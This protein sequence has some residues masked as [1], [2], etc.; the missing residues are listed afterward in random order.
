MGIR[1]NEITTKW[2]F[3]TDNKV[4]MSWINQQKENLELGLGS[5]KVQNI[6]YP[7]EYQEQL[8]YSK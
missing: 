1:K 4:V 8:F 3:M 6:T 2:G 5:N 7:A